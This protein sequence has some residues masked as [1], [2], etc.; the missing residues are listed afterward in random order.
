MGDLSNEAQEA[1]TLN[2]VSSSTPKKIK[3]SEIRRLKREGHS[4]AAIAK[5]LGVSANTVYYHLITK[6]K[7]T[8]AKT[9]L[10][11]QASE[12][13]EFEVFGTVIKTDQKPVSIEKVG[14]RIVIN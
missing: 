8:Q 10:K 3:S 6:K 2:G 14:N 5:K 11:Q 1:S 9:E 13:F 7:R 4:P 12:C